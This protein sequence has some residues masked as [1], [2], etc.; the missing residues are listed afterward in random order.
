MSNLPSQAG[1]FTA[2]SSAFAI[3][4]QSKLD[5]DPNERSAELLRAILLALNQ[6]A[7]A[8]ETLTAPFDQKD[9]PIFAAACVYLSSLLS[10]LAAFAAMWGKRWLSDDL[11]SAG[12]TMIERCGDRQRKRDEFKTWRSWMF[13]ESPPFML[14]I[15]IQLLILGVCANAAP[16]NTV[17]IILIP[18]VILGALY[19]AAS[20]YGTNHAPIPVDPWMEAGFRPVA[21][22]HSIAAAGIS[23][24]KRPLLS[25]TL[26]PLYTLW[27][28]IILPLSRIP[29]AV[30]S[31]S[32]AETW[33]H[34]RGLPMPTT[35]VP[36]PQLP[37][38]RDLWE[39]IQCKL[40]LAMLR[41][42]PTPPLSTAPDTPETSSWLEHETQVTLWRTNANDVRCVSWIIWN[43]TSQE[44]LDLAIQLAG[45]ILWFDEGLGVV[46]PYKLIISILK[47]CFDSSGR[48]RPGSRD[49]AYYCARAALWIGIRAMRSQGGSGFPRPIIRC[50][51]LLPDRDLQEL[52]EICGLEDTSRI[53]A[54]MYHIPPDVSPE[55]LQWTS[56]ALLHLSWAKRNTPGAFDMVGDLAV[57]RYMDTIPSAAIV[58]RLLASCI[59]LGR[60]VDGVVL[61]IQDKSSVIPYFRTPSRSCCFCQRS[62]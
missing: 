38:L 23:L 16:N 7:I 9:P 34:S 58:D 49:R 35:Q 20:L 30:L 17:R 62:L 27:V 59:F 13:I 22:L 26:T 19:V 15:V 28:G 33:C 1:L 53:L 41:F 21:A 61:R 4:L 14:S 32:R 45:M 8:D 25:L 54:R 51:S 52:L 48:L 24:C 11:R 46:P 10:L 44:V 57:E 6:S 42:P 29:R 39:K 2:V 31:L 12:E 40:L 18:V 37:S 55:Y 3:Y 36:T 60:S 47:A 43:I 50:N 56:S 5:P